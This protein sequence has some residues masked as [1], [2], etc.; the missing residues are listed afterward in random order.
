MKLTSIENFVE[1]LCSIPQEDFTIGTVYDYLSKNQVK[2]Q[3]LSRYLF[4][5]KDHY[6]RNLIFKNELFELVAI[7]WDVGQTS[8]IHNHAGQNCWMTMPI[9][10]LRVQNFGVIEQD[11]G[12]GYCRLRPTTSFDIHGELPAEVDPE[13]P[14]HQVLNLSE[15]AR[16]AVSLHIYSKPYDRCLVYS[17]DKHAYGEVGLQ[18]TSEYGSLCEG[19]RL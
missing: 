6:T 13:E 19:R 4:F 12:A 2:E 1:E 14:I 7:C 10:K 17:L 18:Y 16:R 9:G 15:F 8:P 5:S 3:T 11:Q